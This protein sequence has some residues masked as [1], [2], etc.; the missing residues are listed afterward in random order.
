MKKNSKKLQNKNLKIAF[1]NQ[2]DNDSII[3]VKFI[4]NLKKV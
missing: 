4:V 2:H 3:F 1:R